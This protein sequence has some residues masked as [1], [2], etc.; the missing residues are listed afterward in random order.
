MFV[1]LFLTINI[2][3]SSESCDSRTSVY[4]GHGIFNF[5]NYYFDSRTYMESHMAMMPRTYKENIRDTIS[6]TGE[7]CIEGQWKCNIDNSR[8]C[9]NAEHI[10]PKANS[11]K[12]ISG[13]SLDI[14]GNLIM[15]YGK[16]NQELS[17]GGYGEKVAIYGSSIVESAYRSVYRACL[18]NNNPNSY[19]TELCLPSNNSWIYIVIALLIMIS[20]AVFLYFKYI[21]NK[22]DIANI[23]NPISNN[24]IISEDS[25]EEDTEVKL[26]L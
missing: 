2:V 15:A 1:L 12:E 11:I 6:C 14:Q 26:D 18:D 8:D 24:D 3:D 7:W 13:C 10:I 21:R 19:P 16:W 4:N 23:F 22:V 17:N 5:N 9:Y 25:S 20:V